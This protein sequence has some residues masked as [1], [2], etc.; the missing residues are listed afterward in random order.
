MTN[1]TWIGI[2]Y[3]LI[4]IYFRGPGKCTKHE[5][6]FLCGFLFLSSFGMTTSV[7]QPDREVVVTLEAENTKGSVNRKTHQLSVIGTYANIGS[8]GDTHGTLLQIPED[9]CGCGDSLIRQNK[10][11]DWIALFHYPSINSAQTSVINDTECTGVIDRM[12]N[13]MMFG[14]SAILILVMNPKIVKEL[15]VPLMISQPIVLIQTATNVSAI[16]EVLINNVSVKAKIVAKHVASPQTVTVWSTC[17]RPRPGSGVVCHS[18]VNLSKVLRHMAKQALAVMTIR[19][20]KVPGKTHQQNANNRDICAI[21]L[22]NFFPRQT[23]N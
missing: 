15:D 10:P 5:C 2:K 9:E 3:L 1:L 19:R 17:W 18:D 4:R 20:F 22:E 11:G 6:M 16:L 21:C 13:V 14:A 23:C 12:R 8:T 7:L